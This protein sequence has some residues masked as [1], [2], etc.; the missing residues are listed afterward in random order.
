MTDASLNALGA[1]LQQNGHPICFASRTLND[2][3]RNYSATEKELL[4]IVWATNYFRPYLYGVKFEILSDHQ[5][6]RW[7]FVKSQSRELN[8]RLYRWIIKL[9]DFNLT[10]NYLKGKDNQV[11]DS[12]S[13]IDNDSGE[14]H[15]LDSS[16]SN[17]MYNNVD[18][19]ATM[20]SQQEDTHNHIGILDTIVNRFRTQLILTDNK[21]TEMRNVF[22]NR[23]IYINSTDLM[24]N[25]DDIL[26]R[27]LEK[28]KVGI[29]TELDDHKYNILQQR[30]IDLFEGNNSLK[31]V[32]CS[33]HAVDMDSEDETYKQIHNYHRNE[34]EHTGI[35]ENYEGLKRLIYYPNLKVLIQKYVDNCDTCIRSKFDRNPIRPKFK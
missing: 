31:F 11:A 21:T 3:D 29:F 24:N 15:V 7:L 6:L 33:Y 9:S 10:V 19:G 23:K 4:A 1:V 5:P 16:I 20:H 12:L 25:L 18:E 17:S 34:T 35:N 14:I 32:R 30:I 27:N 22:G 26:L 8:P 28:G 13:R 2:N